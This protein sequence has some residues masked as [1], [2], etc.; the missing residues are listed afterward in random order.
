MTFVEEKI[1]LTVRDNLN[2]NSN[3]FAN[4]LFAS[5]AKYLGVL[6]IFKLYDAARKIHVSTHL[7]LHIHLICNLIYNLIHGENFSRL[8]ND[9]DYLFS[10]SKYQ[11]A[12][13]HATIRKCLLCLQGCCWNR[14]STHRREFSDFECTERILEAC[15][16][17]LLAMYASR[18]EWNRES[19]LI[20]RTCTL[21]FID[22]RYIYYGD[23]YLL[24]AV[25]CLQ[26][27]N[28]ERDAYKTRC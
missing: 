1:D 23:R 13:H 10:L 12:I 15:R 25:V 2:N 19:G 21:H 9:W 26:E 24:L 8:R 16:A 11:T 6:R 14:G 28:I 5:I 18:I 4:R 22:P 27:L 17:K 20:N 7:F 3:S